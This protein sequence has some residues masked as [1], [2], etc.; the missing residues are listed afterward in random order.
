[1][2]RAPSNKGANFRI[3][4]KMAA[5]LPPSC[6]GLVVLFLVTE[7]LPI[8]ALRMRGDDVIGNFCIAN[9]GDL[10]KKQRADRI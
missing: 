7:K 8:S 3:F 5:G 10:S 1:M 4:A 6:S 9:E 2:L